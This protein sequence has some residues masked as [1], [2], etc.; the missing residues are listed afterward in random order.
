[1]SFFLVI[2]DLQ[3][4]DPLTQ[5]ALIFSS[6]VHDVDH[7]GVSNHQLV[8]EKSP[9]A[10]LYKNKSVAE[11]NSVDISWWLLMTPSFSDLRGAIYSDASEMR[12]FR[13]L[14]VNTV[15][16]TDILDRDM[17]IHRDRGWNKAFDGK[18]SASP[19]DSI[20]DLRATLAVEH[21]MQAADAA[22]TMQSFRTYLKWSEKIFEEMYQAFHCGRAERDPAK[23]WYVGELAFFDRFVV[24]LASRLQ[25]T[26]VLG[27]SGDEFL[28]AAM[29]NRRLWNEHGKLIVRD[30]VENF[31][32]RVVAAQDDTVEFL[33]A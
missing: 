33:S 32:R 5:F 3:A 28:K 15:V 23:S 2:L 29:E 21:I 26:G 19:F 27:L 12:R 1:M 13:Q 20:R 30:M 18:K 17:K 22:H 9:L 8:K 31:S 10:A 4:S 14:L 6:L 7:V 16:A 11:Q 25:Q 24:P